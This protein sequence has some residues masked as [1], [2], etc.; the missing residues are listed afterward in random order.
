[1]KKFSEFLIEQA[2]KPTAHAGIK[3]KSVSI[4]KQAD[5][6]QW[7]DC[8]ITAITPDNAADTY[9]LTL[10]DG[11]TTKVV[12]TPD[13]VSA[14]TSG[15]EVV[16]THDGF[17]FFFGKSPSKGNVTEAKIDHRKYGQMGRY[18]LDDGDTLPTKGQDIDFYDRNGDKKY[19]KVTAASIKSISV[20]TSD[21]T[22]HKMD[23]VKP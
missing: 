9:N 2:S 5:G 17:E 13:Q 14:V 8:A 4:K 21:G 3:G 6:T 11:N 16:A 15:K 20:K 22:L 1:M 10:T 19:G 18:A 23:V 12:L 7:S